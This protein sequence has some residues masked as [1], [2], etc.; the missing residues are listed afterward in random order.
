MDQLFNALADPSRRLLLHRL[1]VADGQTLTSLCAGHAMTRQAVT[2]HLLQLERAGLLASSWQ[3]REKRHWLRPEPLERVSQWIREF[4]N[5][6]PR[7]E[8]NDE[9]ALRFPLARPEREPQQPLAPAAE[10]ESRSFSICGM[11]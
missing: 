6:A 7:H 11:D 3:G 4:E 5:R 8:E 9:A 10:S 2:K 1:L